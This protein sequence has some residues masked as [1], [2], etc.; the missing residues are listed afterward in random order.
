LDEVLDYGEDESED[1]AQ[2]DEPSDVKRPQPASKLRPT[3]EAE[4]PEAKVELIEFERRV[5][6]INP[7]KHSQRRKEKFEEDRKERDKERL[8][9]PLIVTSQL[10]KVNTIN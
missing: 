4:S 8:R 9:P 2:F 7:N 3:E 6:K 10:M 1:M 5:M